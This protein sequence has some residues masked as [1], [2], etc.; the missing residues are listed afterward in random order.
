MKDFSGSLDRANYTLKNALLWGNFA[1][2]C[3]LASVGKWGHRIVH[4]LMA[5]LEFIPVFSQIISMMELCLSTQFDLRTN[6][7]IYKRLT[8]KSPVKQNVEVKISFDELKKQL[9]SHLSEYVKKKR[10]S[11]AY[12]RPKLLP[13]N[14][15]GANR[16]IPLASSPKG[17]Q[18]FARGATFYG[19]HSEGIRDYGWGCAWRAIQ[20]CLSAYGTSPSFEEL[21]H[22][23]GPVEN[24]KLIYHNQYPEEQLDTSKPFAPY[25]IPTGWAE[26]WIGQLAMHFFEISSALE[27]VNGI[28]QGSYAPHQ[29]FHQKPLRF[30][31][32]RKRLEDHFK[33]ENPAPVMIDDGTYA[34]NIVGIGQ[35][36]LKTILWIADPHIKKEA[37]RVPGEQTPA[38][39]YKVTLDPFGKQIACSLQK[40]DS[41]QKSLLFSPGSYL[42]LHFS[43]KPWMVLF[44]GSKEVLFRSGDLPP[45]THELG[46]NDSDKEL[47]KH[48]LHG[49]E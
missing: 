25:D 6:T 28:P 31:A 22:M 48:P 33:K 4:V 27:T 37:N 11:Q 14:E 24:L 26:P 49:S 42:G 12:Q 38:G 18:H 34:L 21:F 10:E 32:F 19:Y 7:S 23:F 44:P 30:S 2:H 15:K 43:R 36:R 40:E 1:W 39:L 16:L 5:T 41:H 8:H 47:A 45:D 29:V 9:T 3:K 35:H 13:L 20:T 46:D 17:I